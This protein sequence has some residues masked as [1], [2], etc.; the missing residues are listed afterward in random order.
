MKD[1]D[2]SNAPLS[3]Q[4]RRVLLGLGAAGAAL[5]GSSLSSNVLAA[6]QAQVTE[7]PH[8]EKTQDRNLFHGRHQTGI[9]TPRPAAGMLVSFDVLA[10]D[11]EDL[12]R[13]FRTLNERIA[14]LMTGGVVPQVDPKLPPVDSGILGP[15]VTPDNLTI[16][17]SVGESLFDERFGLA[18]V[19]PTRLIRMI[20]FP[21]DALEPDR[22]HGDLSI[23]FCSNTPDSNIHALRDIVK[24]LPD[25][26]LVRW[27]QEGTVPAQAPVKPGQPAESARN[28]LG[29]RDGSANPDSNDQKAMDYLVW[30]QPGSDE[31]AWAVSGSYQAVR[32]IRNFVERWDRTPLQEQQAIFGRVKTTGAP[33]DGKQETDVPNYAADP[34]GKQTRLD[35]HIRMANPRTADT[36]RNRIL[37]R[38]F[39]YSNGVSKNGQLDMGLLFIC[40]QSDLEK[41]FITVQTRLNGEPLEEYLKPIGGGYFFTLPGV[42]GDQDYLGRSLL[43]ASTPT[44]TL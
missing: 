28:F 30:V 9:V 18:S 1:S 31:P 34:H 42:V 38:P 3:A 35:S 11:R 17:V 10:A 37:R 20:G 29:F 4:R 26:L 12:E 13:L 6:S 41:G 5:A 16:T 40:Y 24:N 21:N 33:M 44:K 22:C 36:E 2:M 32:I 19:K 27:K 25:L 39:N 15:V 7:A 8:S 23:Q 43:A 14:F